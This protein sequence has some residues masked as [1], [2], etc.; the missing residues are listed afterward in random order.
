MMT[1]PVSDMLT[2][3]RNAAAAGHASVTLP[4]SR[5]KQIIANILM[6]EGFLTAVEKT[7]KGQPELRL[8]LR[9]EGR[10]AALRGIER[11][12]KPGRRIY[13]KWTEIPVVR[14][15]QGFA[16]ISTSAGIMT[17]GEAKARRLGGELI[18]KVY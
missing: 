14:S 9:R 11:V 1:D 6:R 2:R 16:I 15:N 17:G 4:Y 12:S 10:E 8:E 7:A 3:I 5:L 18:C 13:V